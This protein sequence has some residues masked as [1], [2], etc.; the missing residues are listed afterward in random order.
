MDSKFV[1]VLGAKM[2]YLEM[3]EGDPIIFIHGMPTYSYLWR[4]IMPTL[5]NYGRCIALDLIGMG[6]SD[7]PDIAYRIFDHIRYFDAFIEALSI[8]SATLVMHGWGSVI[9]FDFAKRHQDRI[10]ALAFFESHVRPITDWN[11]LSLPVQQ[12]ASLLDKPELSY[13][14]VIE[15]NYLVEKLLPSGVIRS[16]TQQELEAYKKPFLT[17]E[18]R[19]PL[20]QYIKD[21]PLGQGPDDVVALIT[22]YSDWLQTTTI[23]KLMLFAVP[24]FITTMDTVQWARHHLPNLTQEPL[25]DVLHFAQESVPELF[26]EK[27]LSWYKS[28]VCENYC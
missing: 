7:K 18:S 17:L 10:T 26:S 9:G 27:L 25:D 4:N 8:K 28:V 6:E 12:L 24:G 19:K 2:H 1:N 14:A 3:G 23:A 22:R 20:W 13:R 21:L 11:M 15:Q 5:S 16:L